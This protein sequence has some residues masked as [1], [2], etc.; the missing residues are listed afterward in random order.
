MAEINEMDQ[1]TPPFAAYAGNEPYIFISYSHKD[2]KI[3]FEQIDRYQKMGF[4]IWYDEGISPGTNFNRVIANK[5]CSCSLFMLF[6]SHNSMASEYVENEINLAINEKKELMVIHIKETSI[7]PEIKILISKLDHIY[8]NKMSDEAYMLRIKKLP[9]ILK[10]GESINAELL[11]KTVM[12]DYPSIISSCYT[13]NYSLCNEGVENIEKFKNFI[14]LYENII[15]YIFIIYLTFYRYYIKQPDTEIENTLKSLSNIMPE[16]IFSCTLSL[17]EFFKKS[18]QTLP[19]INDLTNILFKAKDDHGLHDNYINLIKYSAKKFHVQQPGEE[20]RF[21]EIFDTLT[22]YIR[23]YSDPSGTLSYDETVLHSQLHECLLNYILSNF[24]IFKIY[25][26]GIISQIDKTKQNKFNHTL[27]VCSGDVIGR[28]RK[29]VEKD[30]PLAH[31]HVYIFA[32]L[33]NPEPFLDLYPFIIYNKCQKDN[34]NN[35]FIFNSK[36]ETGKINYRCSNCGAIITEDINYSELESFFWYDSWKNKIETSSIQKNKDHLYNA[37]INLLQSKT[38]SD[39]INKNIAALRQLFPLPDKEFNEV[40]Q[41]AMITKNFNEEEEIK[42]LISQKPE[43]VQLRAKLVQFY[44]KKHQNQEAINELIKIVNILISKQEWDKAKK[45]CEK[46][47]SISN[48]NSEIINL[49]KIIEEGQKAKPAASEPEL[50]PCAA[51]SDTIELWKYSTGSKISMLQIDSFNDFTYAGMANGRFIALDADG[52]VR[53]DKNYGFPVKRL[54][55]TSNY[56]CLAMWN[57]MMIVLSKPSFD[58]VFEHILTLPVSE[59]KINCV[60]G[61]DEFLFASWDGGIYNFSDGSVSKIISFQTGVSAFDIHK[62]LEKMAIADLN[63]KI[64][65]YDKDFKEQWNVDV[66]RPLVK[67]KFDQKENGLLALSNDGQVMLTDT[68][69]NSIVNFELNDRLIGFH[70][71]SQKDSVFLFTAQKLINVAASYENR[72]ETDNARAGLKIS[73]KEFILSSPASSFIHIND[74][75]FAF[76]DNNFSL[77]SVSNFQY[78]NLLIQNFKNEYYAADRG[79]IKLTYFNH[80]NNEIYMKAFKK[81]LD[82]LSPASIE[83]EVILRGKLAFDEATKISIVLTNRGQKKASKASVSI[84]GLIREPIFKQISGPI[85]PGGQIT[86]DDVIL[87]SVKGT[88]KTTLK[89]DYDDGSGIIKKIEREYFW[90]VIK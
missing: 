71:S 68:D 13:N 74:N 26:P 37:I 47:L 17:A 79:G 38:E 87:P 39:A 54:K 70:S 46:G 3:V 35:L 59:I 42:K 41:K 58:T 29:K 19:F 81:K 23:Y 65:L 5:L 83:I 44:V 8:M 62:S 7:P 25:L 72:Q 28:T 80:E 24:T 63:G 86:I 90:E 40:L 12:T 88:V 66:N 6:V 2:T 57:G 43:D 15:K 56:L 9:A 73:Q 50:K 1:I 21:T 85:R 51:E 34:S 89:A 49:L 75:E 67:L 48:E 18:Q 11:Y 53:F 27:I 77:S 30:E 52:N 84:T 55:I 45:L 33:A 4:R 22:K 64:Y 10:A 60:N 20:I 16:N 61:K 78:E 31:E 14:R 76:I 36:S 32:N 82:M 69:K